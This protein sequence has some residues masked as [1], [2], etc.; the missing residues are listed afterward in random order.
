MAELL[1]TTDDFAP[2]GLAC[3]GVPLLI[4]Q[5]MRLIEPA[6]AWLLHI[7]LVRGRTR[8]PKT[9]RTYGEVLYD[10]W[11]T[12]ETNGW[13]WDAVGQGELVA[14][15]N[16]ML[17]QP[18][19]YTRK[20]FK[21]STINLRIGTIARFYKWCAS[22]GL[23]DR[24]P[25]PA[26]EIVV[27]RHQPP[28]F[29]AHVDA[30]GGRKQVNTMTVRH[31]PLPPQPLSPAELRLIMAKMR[32]RDRLIVEWA[33]L[34]GIRRKEVAGLRRSAL[35]QFQINPLPGMTIDVTKGD[36][37][38][39]IH[40]TLSLIDRTRAYMREE[41]A[42][43]VRHA[44]KRS[45]AYTEPDTIFLTDDGLAM[46]PR[47]VGAIFSAAAKEAGVDASFHALRHTFAT[48]MLRILQRRAVLA[49]EINPLL[50]LQK[51]LGHANVATTSIYLR[52]LQT[53]MT[54]V[55]AAVDD[56]YEAFR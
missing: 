9:W 40:P 27:S 16:R 6:C 29:L 46:S 25:F 49:P 41:R 24:S 7:A 47:R 3:P 10:W 55:E 8:S 48:A 26:E 51:L 43:A 52:V 31:R 34:T 42:V 37:P 5:E 39:M 32:P 35:P 18:S 33:Y 1:F 11:Q 28:G 20:P 2:H 38:R 45:A 54:L 22:M 23:T 36:N 12:L 17:Q 44:Q 21:R 53:D 19:D 14:Y 13:V 4:D 56:L 15:R 50:V 30:S